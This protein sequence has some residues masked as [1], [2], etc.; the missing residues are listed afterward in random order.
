MLQDSK[1]FSWCFLVECIFLRLDYWWRHCI[2]VKVLSEISN[3]LF[4]KALIYGIGALDIL[5][6][7][8]NIITKNKYFKLFQVIKF[9]F[10]NFFPTISTLLLP[11]PIFKNLEH[12]ALRF[13][14]AQFP[15]VYLSIQLFIPFTV[16][17]TPIQTINITISFLKSWCLNRLQYQNNCWHYR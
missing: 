8:I 1:S 10:Y 11:K 14:L 7:A 16:N 15:L 2:K 3:S 4:W 5:G 9:F 12:L 6:F 13:I 17:V